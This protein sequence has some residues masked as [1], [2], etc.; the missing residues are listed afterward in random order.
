MPG[1]KISR[2]CS[3]E[4][5]S[6]RVVPMAQ[7]GRALMPGCADR[8]P[9]YGAIQRTSASFDDRYFRPIRFSIARWN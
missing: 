7:A 9:K 2:K 6:R 4:R 5:R 3:V 8:E 1:R